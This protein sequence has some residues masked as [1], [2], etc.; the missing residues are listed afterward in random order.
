MPFPS[1]TFPPRYE[2]QMA[3]LLFS[4]RPFYVTLSFICVALAG[5]LSYRFTLAAV[6]KRRKAILARMSPMELE[7][8]KSNSKRY[9]D[10]KLTFI[11]GL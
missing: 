3:D 2:Y 7:D 11:Y 8:E 9:A 10:R 1:A 6:N 5:Y 4:G